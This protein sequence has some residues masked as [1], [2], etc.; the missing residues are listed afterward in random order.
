M[1]GAPVGRDHQ[2]GGEARG[3]RLDEDMHAGAGAR[4]GQRVAHHPARRIAGRD[5]DQL[6]AG[7]QRDVRDLAG[8]RIELVERAFRIRIDLDGVDIG[9][10]RRLDPGRAR[11]FGD[12]FHRGDRLGRGPAWRRG[13]LREGLQLAGQRKRHGRLDN[14]DDPRRRGFEAGRFGI[15]VRRRGARD[16]RRRAGGQAG[17]GG[18]KHKGGQGEKR[19]HQGRSPVTRSSPQLRLWM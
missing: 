11:P 2:V 14:L 4:T 15:P 7:L 9:V 13:Q 19:A 8:A 12:G 16:G 18:G 5:R 10:R 1:V 6:L 3:D 17:A